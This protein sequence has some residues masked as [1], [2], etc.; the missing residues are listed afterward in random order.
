MNTET[1]KPAIQTLKQPE[2]TQ[3]ELM[4]ISIN[5]WILKHRIV[6]ENEKPVEFTT[7]RCLIEPYSDMS[8]DQVVVKASQVGWT[9][10]DIIKSAYLC[11][12]YG[13]NVIYVLPTRSVVKDFVAPKV[14]KLYRNNPIISEHLKKD[15]E[16]LKQLGNRFI[17]FRGAFSPTEAISL[18]ADLVV[19]DEYDRSNQQ[20]LETYESRLDASD[21]G[22]YWRFSN[23][24]LP[25]FGV[26]EMF[27]TSDQRHW[28]V[29]C[30][31]CGHA[32]FIDWQPTGD[33]NHYV[34]IIDNTKGS[35][36]GYYACGKCDKELSDAD[37]QNG[38]WV[39]K[40]PDRKR[41]GYWL[42][43]M[44]M[45]YKTAASIIAKSHGDQ[46]V[47]YNF[48]LGKAYQP[49]ELSFTDDLF[50]SNL[51]PGTHTK[52]PYA[53]GVD[54]GKVKHWVVENAYGVVA[55]GATEDWQEIRRIRNHYDALCV[56]DANPYPNEPRKMVDEFPGKVYVNYYIEDSK[57]LGTI[58]WLEGDNAGVV[59]TDRTRIFDQYI[60]DLSNNQFTFYQTTTDLRDSG[61]IA[62]HTNMFRA[63][64]TDA[65]GRRKGVWFTKP[66]APDHFAH[67]TIYA[68]IAR[69]QIRAAAGA[70]I[71][72]SQP[73][74]K[75]RRIGVTITERGIEST[76]D[77]QEV[78]R[79]S[80]L[81]QRNWRSQ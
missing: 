79:K 35:E 20:V 51:S 48:T 8:P 49:A 15:S 13:F 1:P 54:N 45:P 22:Y 55:H 50:I 28:F 78:A 38:F 69:T 65:R 11:I 2:L 76:V 46:S 66:N 75:H 12:E 57:N 40:Y 77:P 24:S 44:M 53:M 81:K 68:N 67:A 73:P 10:K 21:Y 14:D 37:R 4:H 71:T 29:K 41:R 19:G 25:G 33:K 30:H 58:R 56:I 60:S 23:P 3:D 26:D 17:Y 42:S 36:K 16:N 5:S 52:T 9:V 70:G 39:A 32:W 47:F 63:V 80:T 59:H 43:Q 6:T 61:Y 7:H 34:K 27:S 72:R 62:H 64:E 18:T 31:H 74:V